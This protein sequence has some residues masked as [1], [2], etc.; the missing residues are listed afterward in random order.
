VVVVMKV[1][2]SMVMPASHSIDKSCGVQIAHNVR[3]VKLWKPTRVV[4]NLLTPAFV[5]YDLGMY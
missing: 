3:E 2:G 1:A 4:L 5:V